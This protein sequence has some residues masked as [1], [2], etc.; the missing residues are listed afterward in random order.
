[1][2]I[3]DSPML[4]QVLALGWADISAGQVGEAAV[5]Q[6]LSRR[7]LK[8]HFHQRPIDESH[9]PDFRA[10]QVLAERVGV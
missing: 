2:A 7:A 5:R 3:C 8:H 4:V 9:K 6:V 1:M 10:A